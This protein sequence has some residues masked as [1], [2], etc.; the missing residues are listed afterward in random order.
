ME[1]QNIIDI[2]KYKSLDITDNRCKKLKIKKSINKEEFKFLEQI[3]LT[4]ITTNSRISEEFLLTTQN[5]SVIK[6]NK[7]IINFINKNKNRS[8]YQIFARYKN[9]N[10]ST[11]IEKS[12]CNDILLSKLIEKFQND[13]K[14]IEFCIKFYKPK[15][16]RNSNDMDID[17]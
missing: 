5:T 7:F 11:D 13:I 2:L 16:Y 15:N 6:I 17:F 10:I 12:I 4:E 9:I 1:I 8:K 14:N 3:N